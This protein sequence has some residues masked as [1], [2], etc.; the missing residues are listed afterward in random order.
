MSKYT[1]EVR[2]ICETLAEYDQSQGYGKVSE[3]INKSWDKIFDFDFPIFDEDYRSVLCKKILMHYYTREIGLETVGLW[4]LKLN[5]KMIEIMPY[6]NKLYES[7]LIQYNP[8][9][10][11]DYRREHTGSDGGSSVSNRNAKGS[12]EDSIADTV[13][14]TRVINNSGV[15]RNLFSDTPQGA[16]TGVEN[17][18]YLT[19]ARKITSDETTT[20]NDNRRYD[21]QRNGRRE[22]NESG[23]SSYNN[24]NEF[25]EHVVGKMPGKSY[26]KM[27]EEYRATLL[28]IDMMI[29]G[30][31]KNLFMLLW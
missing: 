21:S 15:N 12:N 10:D 3:I 29:I 1:T 22:N 2:F 5:T 7:A 14:D 13:V 31:L 8:I 27:I 6:Y 4:K 20:D 23:S 28:N 24:T 26:A 17:E 30:E 9:F 16:L 18:N 25:V 19:D 11:A